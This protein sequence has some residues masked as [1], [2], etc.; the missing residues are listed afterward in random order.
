V[1]E[2]RCVC[3]LYIGR[4]GARDGSIQLFELFS[5]RLLA[6]GKSFKV[7][8]GRVHAQAVDDPEHHRRNQNHLARKP[9]R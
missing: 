7:M 6:R 9:T 1:A 2:R 3:T 4:A 8:I 5:Q